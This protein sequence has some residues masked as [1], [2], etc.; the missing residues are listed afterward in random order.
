MLQSLHRIRQ[1]IC[2]SL[3]PRPWLQPVSILLLS[4][5]G[6][7]GSACPAFAHQMFI[8]PTRQNDRVRVEVYFEDDSPADDAE[9]ELR[10]ETGEVMLRG[11]ADAK[12]VW[13]FPCPVAG[14]Y[15]LKATCLGHV[16]TIPWTVA[17][18]PTSDS[19]QQR[20]ENTRTP[21][22]GVVGGIL[23]IGL[24]CTLWYWWRQRPASIS[25]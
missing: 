5:L 16:A 9:I 13:T 7:L 8:Q 14:T 22:W 24:G 20:A 15:L 25:P 18:V 4:W 1:M 6:I 19:S 10:G 11:K 3:N 21:W 2:L 12:G 17:D 23:V